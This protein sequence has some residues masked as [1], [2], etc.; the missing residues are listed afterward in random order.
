MKESKLGYKLRVVK[1]ASFKKF[2]GVV[3]KA[4]ELSGNSKLYTFFDILKSMRKYGAGYFDYIIFQFWELDD[5]KRDTY[6]TRFRS[7]KL[8]RHMNNPEY[9]HIFDDKAEFNEVFKD[10]IGREFLDIDVASEDEIRKFFEKRTKIFAKARDN[11]CGIGLEK[12]N[13]SD[14]DN[15]EEFMAYIKKQ[16]F[17][18]LEDV[19]E[20]HPDLAK[21]Y[22][23]SANCM[24]MITMIG[25]DGKPHL[26]YAVQ[27][28]GING[29]VVDNYGVHGPLD[30]E[31]G[32]FLYPAHSGD[33]K[34]E[35]LYYEHPNSHEKLVGFK[36]PLFKEA[37]EMVL[38]AAMVVPELRYIGW[39]VAVTP[40]GPAIIEGNNYCAHDFWQLPGQRENDMGIIPE[41]LKI[42]PSFE[43]K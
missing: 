10:Y 38:N 7:K 6:L 12:L 23:D 4:S 33:T 8:I 35:G 13:T 25:D 17:A 14:F 43:Y 29:R 3:D 11:S 1:N 24:R 39:D 40:N 26:I 31:T 16:N 34:A 2:L 37:K 22:P 41:I 27:K 19:I 28:F 18:T 30:L 15:F 32:E 20:N 36:T 42:V 9:S 5:D 21:V